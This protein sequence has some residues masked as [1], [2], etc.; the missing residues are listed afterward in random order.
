MHNF[1]AAAPPIAS[2]W[3]R[4]GAPRAQN[5]HGLHGL[6]GTAVAPMRLPAGAGCAPPGGA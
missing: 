2:C 5:L 4:G 1:K 6:H 3:P